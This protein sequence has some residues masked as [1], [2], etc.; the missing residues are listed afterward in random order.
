[1]N[2]LKLSK[3]SGNN[4]GDLPAVPGD[5]RSS[6]NS[7]AF[8]TQQLAI[9]FALGIP[10]FLLFC[11]MRKRWDKLYNS[12]QDKRKSNLPPLPES[13]FGWL[14]TVFNVTDEQVLQ[15][16]GLDAFVFLSFFKMAIKFL[17]AAS[18]FGWIVVAP[19][20]QYTGG[21]F[22]LQPP[23]LNTDGSQNS[24]L[25]WAYVLFVY[26]FSGITCYFLWK[27]TRNITDVRQKFLGHRNS[28][29]DRTV[30]IKGVPG[31]LR[32][33]ESL[34]NH[35]I[36]LDIGEVTNVVICR[37]WRYL[38]G[39]V[40]ERKRILRKLERYWITHM[41]DGKKPKDLDEMRAGISSREY[42]G[43]AT[44]PLLHRTSHRRPRI[45]LGFLGIFG[46]SIDAIDHFI[47][48]LE[49]IDKEIKQAR[50]RAYPPTANAF[51]TFENLAS[52]QLAAQAVLDSDPLSVIAKPACAPQDVVWHN[53]H[54]SRRK[55]ALRSSI[56]F[57]LSA[58]IIVLWFFP[59]GA[60]AAILNI[61]TLRKFLPGIAGLL[62]KTT[63]G[64]MLVQGF[65]PTLAFVL[66]N[67][68]VPYLFDLIALHQGF[69]SRGDAELS[70][71]SKNFFYLFFN[72]FL[73]FT[74][75]GTLSNLHAMAKDTTQIPIM[76][77]ASLPGVAG[78]YV[79]LIVLQGIGVF[80][81]RLLQ[82]GNL[83]VYP[84]IKI[85]AKTPRDHAKLE[86][87]PVFHY[88][89]FLPMPIMVFILCLVYS[90]LEP[91]IL[92]FGLFYFVIGYFVH[93][94]QLLYSMEHPHHSTGQAWMMI[95]RRLV[96][97]LVVFQLT[98]SGMLSLRKA[99]QLSAAIL[100][101]V[102]TMVFVFYRL[103]DQAFT[104]LSQHISLESIHHPSEDDPVVIQSRD[105][106]EQYINPNMVED[107]EEMWAAE[108][109]TA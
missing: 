68:L 36:S 30:R 26:A 108:Y 102:F 105:P 86:E 22:T 44:E 62:E 24:G 99:F 2:P 47:D 8:L 17:V 65:L 33:E 80:P 73:I 1:M 83:F 5:P 93:K 46:T 34:R 43:S 31:H 27:Q 97:G 76:L 56:A 95:I 74:V 39:L 41:N 101:L 54:L 66:F 9:A 104:P 103:I 106:K 96:I 57:I 10:A 92:I 20:N 25:L 70:V 13:T 85:G 12:L 88:G 77:A 42:L 90:I 59:V 40:A 87:A 71:V 100:P 11:V 16:A 21:S 109:G 67:A 81:F 107:F 32:S 49:D 19:I 64:T 4:N 63:L 69:V 82:I 37:D 18:L 6:I 84:F 28:I 91:K 51:V 94:Y 3:T 72:L 89:F 53:A 98:M 29:T 60:I 7:Q 75:A 78:F 38:D 23:K 15:S 45:K 61:D 55:R 52:A 35:I 14:T 58:A 50:R 79:N 48:R